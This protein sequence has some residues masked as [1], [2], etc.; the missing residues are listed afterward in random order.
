MG[1][2][3]TYSDVNTGY[4]PTH[5]A[6]KLAADRL[7]ILSRKSEVGGFYDSREA[8][9]QADSQMLF[10]DTYSFG[11]NISQKNNW[12]CL[13]PFGHQVHSPHLS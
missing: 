13:P 12:R 11:Y 10:F 2:A 3:W 7:D 9:D 6:L 1:A 5:Q 4:K 8:V